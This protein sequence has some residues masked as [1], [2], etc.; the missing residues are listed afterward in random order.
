MLLKQEVRIGNLAEETRK[1]EL[2]SV[3]CHDYYE[4]NDKV[5]VRVEHME[6]I[7][8]YVGEEITTTNTIDREDSFGEVYPVDISEDYEIVQCDDLTRTFSIISDK[9]QDMP[10]EEM[11][12]E[13]EDNVLY[14][15]FTFSTW[16]FYRSWETHEIS[17]YV[18]YPSSES[19][20]EELEFNGC[21]YVSDTEL[22]WRYDANVDKIDEFV[23][24]VF[25]NDKYACVGYADE[26]DDIL[27]EYQPV[28]EIPSTACFTDELHIRVR[29]VFSKN[30][31][32]IK[33][34]L[35][36]KECNDGTIT[37]ISVRRISFKF[38]DVNNLAVYLTLP[39]TTVH[40]PMEF[41]TANDLYQEQNLNDSFIQD[42]ITRSKNGFVEMEKLV[43]H[44]VFKI[45]IQNEK[46]V[47][48][49]IRKIKFNLHFRKRKQD[50]W[51]VDSDGLWNGMDENGLYGNVTSSGGI[52]YF[53]YMP[54]DVDLTVDV[55]R[56]SDLLKYLGFTDTDVRY[57]KSKLKKS[58]LR[59][60]FYDSPNSARQNLLAYSTIFMDSGMLF[61]KMMR[62]ANRKNLYVVSGQQT[63]I[64]YDNLKVDTEPCFEEHTKYSVE[65]VE[66]MRLSSQIV[67]SDR[68]SQ[69]CSE[70]FY[71]YLWAD[72]DN[73]A[74]PTDIYLRIDF[75]HAGYGRVVPMTMP[76]IDGSNANRI[77]T[78]EEICDKWINHGGWG[79]LSNEKYSYIHLQYA[80]DSNTKRHVYYLDPDTYGLGAYNDRT[81]D[82]MEIN[83]YEPK[84][85]F[86]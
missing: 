26:G 29:V 5:E 50:G 1:M 64:K 63:D 80:Y 53:S 21:E 72:N 55:G 67:V 61:E 79:V 51:I 54:N 9:Y 47:Y 31:E 57:Q 42:Q 16:H 71:L 83:L 75:N 82:E 52:K 59:L 36:D 74:I 12:F 65:E 18:R 27:E 32:C 38:K 39:L 37:D 56:Q 6:D 7:A 34:E 33:W 45:G 28:E 3:S 70:G 24:T 62:G 85:N 22:K 77:Y 23:C 15:H 2:F 84:I 46:P 48:A 30:P 49:P 41:K 66:E 35:Y 40:I 8:L 69:A 58:F 43:Y 68:F 10:L 11:W 14:I 73:G 13:V 76:Y 44:P 20:Y 78:M 19:G 81:P 86:Q 17:F 60:S 25:R 4:D